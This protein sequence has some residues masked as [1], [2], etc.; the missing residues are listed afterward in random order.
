[1]GDDGESRMEDGVAPFPAPRAWIAPLALITFLGSFLGGRV[2]HAGM[3]PGRWPSR[4]NASSRR[5]LTNG[6]SEGRNPKFEGG[7]TTSYVV[8]HEPAESPPKPWG[9][10]REPW[11]LKFQSARIQQS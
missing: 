11:N 6:K 4:G 9:G 10:K 2:P 8:A 3:G 7:K 5:L 1:M